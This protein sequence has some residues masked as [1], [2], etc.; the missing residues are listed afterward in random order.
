MLE[1]LRAW[2]DLLRDLISG[3]WPEQVVTV[4]PP[5]PEPAEAPDLARFFQSPDPG[6]PDLR[7]LLPA[8]ARV[9]DVGCGVG[10]N[11]RALTGQG[12]LPIGVDA[13]ATVLAQARTTS[14][15]PLLRADLFDLPLGDASVDAAVAWQVLCQFDPGS[16]RAALRELARVVAPGGLLVVSG[17][18][19]SL[20]I[21]GAELPCGTEPADAALL[22]P[23]ADWPHRRWLFI[24][25]R[26]ADGLNPAPGRR[27]AA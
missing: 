12:F 27:D 24:A 3:R 2:V 9:L 17:C 10:R 1:S 23:L 5:S 21:D 6:F 4:A 22:D 20:P 14:D 7:P 11:L 16:R 19:S 25:R 18:P 8:R 15:A 26:T 13:S